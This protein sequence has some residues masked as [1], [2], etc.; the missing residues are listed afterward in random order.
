[1]HAHRRTAGTTLL[2]VWAI[3]TLLPGVSLGASGAGVTLSTNTFAGAGESGYAPVPPGMYAR[4]GLAWLPGRH[5]E[6]EVYHIPQRTPRPY[7]QVFFGLQ[8]GWWFLERKPDC[9]LNAIVEAGVLYGLD[10]TVLLNLKVTPIVFGCP[11]F[12]YAERFC[13]LGVL[14]DPQR[15]RLLGQLQVLALSLFLKR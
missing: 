5:L 1:M 7:S 2:L 11:G 6:I 4:G 12:G 10:Q 8:A 9:Y 14:F 15:Q 3:T 13:S